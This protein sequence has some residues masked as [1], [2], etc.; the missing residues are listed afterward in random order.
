MRSTGGPGLSLV[1]MSISTPLSARGVFE[2]KS[3]T[4]W[5][6]A[7]VLLSTEKLV[8]MLAVMPSPSPQALT[9]FM[10]A[11]SLLRKE[12]STAVAEN[13]PRRTSRTALYHVAR[14]LPYYL[15]GRYSPLLC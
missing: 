2:G 8:S 3:I 13:R 11:V 10:K 7:W 15:R 12:G 5:D 1:N 4:L 9:S 14:I 6:S